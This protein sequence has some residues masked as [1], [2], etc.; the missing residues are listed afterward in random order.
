MS[1]FTRPAPVEPSAA[2]RAPT[3]YYEAN[4]CAA[5]GSVRFERRVVRAGEYEVEVCV[6][7]GACLDRA[8]YESRR[9]SR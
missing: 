7:H 1:W 8:G 3:T 4:R 6:D 2:E 5:C 9:W